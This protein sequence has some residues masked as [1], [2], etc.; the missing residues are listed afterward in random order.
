MVFVRE[1][2]TPAFHLGRNLRTI[3]A[4]SVTLDDGTELDA[5]L[6]VGRGRATGANGRAEYPRRSPAVPGRAV[7]LEPALRRADRLRRPRR[8]LGPDPGVG[9]IAGK[10]CLVGFRSAG[11]IVAAATIYRDQDSLRAEALM[12]RDDQPGL[13]ALFSPKK[14]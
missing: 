11:K 4:T 3:G 13:E 6:V 8:E 1:R 2:L 12:E 5:D 10:D 7:L 9:S 14:V